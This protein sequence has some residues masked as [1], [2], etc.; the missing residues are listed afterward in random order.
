MKNNKTYFNGR[1]SMRTILFKG[2][3]NQIFADKYNHGKSE[4]IYGLYIQQ[5]I[6]N[7]EFQP[8]IQINNGSSNEIIAIKTDSLRQYVG[9]KDKNSKLLF[10][11]DIIKVNLSEYDE[12]VMF[13]KLDADYNEWEAGEYV[14]TIYDIRNIPWAYSAEEDDLLPEVEIIDSI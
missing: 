12:D 2:L 1:P 9:Y 8:A 11:G 5:L 4:W 10:E 13:D 14:T 7:N 6:D 3:T